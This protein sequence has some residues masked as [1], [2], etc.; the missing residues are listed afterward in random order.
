MAVGTDPVTAFLYKNYKGEIF[1]RK[2]TTYLVRYWYLYVVAIVCMIL[3]VSL[4]MLSPQITKRIIDDVIGKNKM[5]MLVPMLV[6]IFLIGLGRCVFGYTKE[7]IFDVA[8]SK[9]ATEIRKNLFAHIQN[10]SV[11]FFNNY[12]TG[13]LMSRVKDDVDRIWGAIGYVGML[14]VEVTIH[15]AIVLTCMYQLNHKLFVIPMIAMPIVGIFAIVMEQKLNSIYEHISEENAALNTVA[16]E[17]LAGVRTV[18][19][20]AREKF[21]IKKFLS[22][23]KRYYELNMQQSKVLI[24]YQ[25]LFQVV[26]KLLPIITIVYGGYLVMHGQMT[27][28]SLGAFIEY[29]GNIVWPMEMLGWLFNDLAAALASNKRIQKIYREEPDIT[30][31]EEPNKVEAVDGHITFEQVDFSL[32]GME[33]LHDISFDVKPGKT[34]GIMGA[35]GSG[36]SSIIKLLQRFY[37]VDNG[38]IL[39][40][41]IDIKNMTFEDIRKNIALVMQ[42]I[43]LFSDTIESNVKFGRQVETELAEVEEA[44]EQ[45]QATEFIS[46]MENR[47]Q[48]LIG[49]RGVGLSG[50]QKQ[51]ISIAR[52]I[53][54]HAPILVLDDST[55]ALDMETEHCIQNNL[56]KLIDTTKIIIAHRISAVCNADE[57]IILKDGCIAERGTHDELLEQKGLYY[58]TYMAQYGEILEAM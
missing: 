45:A 35:T 12:N 18:K 21:E 42:D 40:D 13:E 43:F 38:R 20:F 14:I 49:E 24:R 53:S 46:G 55:S 52:A 36:K 23:N 1:M 26:T 32:D 54:K 19:A 2:L 41:G 51:R 6:M 58:E 39:I 30:E 9:I 17:N 16:Q 37:D 57:I 44:L 4:D 47:Y 5:D 3:Q 28:G 29:C 50:G 25:P 22:H 34:I 7:F 31:V 10:L 33:I 48:T 8:S 27:L 15:T 11:R 56:K